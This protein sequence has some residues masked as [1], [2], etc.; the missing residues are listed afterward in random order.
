MFTSYNSKLISILKL[1][2]IVTGFFTEVFLV[3]TILVSG[4]VSEFDGP[5]QKHEDIL[6]EPIIE[7][8]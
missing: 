6:T 4:A 8:N 1:V 5:Q 2:T 3:T 7:S